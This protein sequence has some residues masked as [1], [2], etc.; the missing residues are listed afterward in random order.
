MSDEKKLLL[1]VKDL[2]VHFSIA[3]KSAYFDKTDASESR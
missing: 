2:K 3:P 1:D